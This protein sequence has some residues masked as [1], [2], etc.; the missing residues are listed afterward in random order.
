MVCCLHMKNPLPDPRIIVSSSGIV[1]PSRKNLELDPEP[2]SWLPSRQSRR[3][4]ASDPTACD[5]PNFVYAPGFKCTHGYEQWVPRPSLLGSHAPGPVDILP[6]QTEQAKV[7]E[8]P[9]LPT[10]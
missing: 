4:G 9:H 7:K 1:G 10:D 5:P 2:R 6:L 3:S 8:T